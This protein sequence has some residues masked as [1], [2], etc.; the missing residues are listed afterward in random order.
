MLLKMIY[1]SNQKRS[2]EKVRRQCKETCV[3]R[4]GAES[5]RREGAEA[6]ECLRHKS[7]LETGLG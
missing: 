2:L 4:K 1:S 6:E 3:W 5:P 7:D